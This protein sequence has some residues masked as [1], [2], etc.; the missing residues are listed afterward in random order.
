M[1]LKE[2]YNFDYLFNEAENYIL[3]ELEKQ[4][5]KDSNVC[6]C[7][8]CILDMAAYALNKVQPLYRAS[9]LGRLYTHSLHKGDYEKRIK[10]AVQSAIKKVSENPMHLEE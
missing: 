3:S 5:E 9:L 8:D 7:E 2:K 4:L 6:K 1:P 10:A